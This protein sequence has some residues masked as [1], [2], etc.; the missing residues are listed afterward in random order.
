MKHDTCSIFEVFLGF[1]VGVVFLLL[2]V[3]GTPS[4]I[5]GFFVLIG[6]GGIG[7]IFNIIIAALGFLATFFFGLCIF[8]RVWRC[9]F[10]K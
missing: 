8:K 7:T 10:G 1:L 2:T 6:L 5:T 3:L 4:L 9:C